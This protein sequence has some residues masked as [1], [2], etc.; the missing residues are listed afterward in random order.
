MRLCRYSTTNRL[1]YKSQ[2]M[3]L[4]LKI[5]AGIVLAVA[6]LSVA[7][8]GIVALSQSEDKPRL[9]LVAFNCTTPP[10]A[11]TQAPCVGRVQNTGSSTVS[12]TIMITY[13]QESDTASPDP[14]TLLPGQIAVFSIPLRLEGDEPQ[15]WFVVNGKRY[16]LT[17]RLR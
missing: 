10:G 6:I 5:A 12:A 16:Q 15:A 13:G 14:A 9:E 2:A 17:D 4:V 11:A 7:C 1:W 8:V 3:L